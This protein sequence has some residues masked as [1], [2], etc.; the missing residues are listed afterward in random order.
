MMMRE[1]KFHASSYSIILEPIMKLFTRLFA[2]FFVVPATYL[3][4]YWVP[5]S[6]LPTPLGE[7]YLGILNVISLLCAVAT[8][9]YIWSK[10]ES[11]PQ[12]LLSNIMVG[13]ILFGGVGFLAGF[14]GPIIFT[15]DASQG[16]LFGIFITGPLGFVL[17][18]IAGF[19][20]WSRKRN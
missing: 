19:L 1:T 16:P 3:F 15:P 5:F 13:A 9:W 4:V 2:V 14:L 20:Y 6:L 10:L 7:Q 12:G 8:G 17:G 11:V 18:G